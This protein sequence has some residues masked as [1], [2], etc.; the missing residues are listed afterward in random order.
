MTTITLI[1]PG[2]IGGTVG[3]ALMEQGHDVVICANQPFSEL[4][5]T[6][7]DTKERRSKPVRVITSPAELASNRPADWVLFCVKSHQSDGAAAWLKAA[8]GPAGKLAVLQNGVEHRE[9]VAPYVGPGTTVVPVMIMLPA[10]RTRPGEIT[11]QGGASLTA[12]DDETGRA[13]AALFAGSFVRAGVDPDFKSRAWEKLCLN[14]PGGALSVLTL[15][16]GPIA[17]SQ[18]I[19]ALA[20]RFVEECM[21]VGR[22][23]GA[24]FPDGFA[25]RV[26]AMFSAPGGRGNSM[27]YDRRDGKPLEWDARNGVVRR[28]GRK[29]G[30]PTPISDII[31]PMLK[32]LS[33]SA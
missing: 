20:H 16:P 23:E 26:V 12:P 17:E 25:D 22:A 1:G 28:L 24:R 13:F 6:R 10:E 2:A 7:S 18:E 30:I 21:T 29:H 9:H 19:A 11:L 27:Y 5:L 31:V 3:F 14:A 4:S 15:H 33:S 32:L 8:L